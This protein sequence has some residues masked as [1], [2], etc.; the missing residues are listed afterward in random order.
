[1]PPITPQQIKAAFGFSKL[2]FARECGEAF[3]HDRFRTALESFHYLAERTGIGTLTAPPGCGKSVLLGTFLEGLSKTA[4]YPVYLAHTTCGTIDL[5]R[6]ILHGFGVEPAYRKAD[7]YRQLQERLLSLSRDKRIRPLIAIDEAQRLS[8]CFLE[9]IR[10]FTNFDC[11]RSEEVVLILA[12]HPQLTSNL[13]LAINEPL[14]QRIIVRATLGPF[15]RDEMVAYVHFRLKTVGRSAPIFTE[16][17]LEA[18]YKASRGI[19]RIIDHLAER[20]LIEALR[21]KQ[22]E[23]NSQLVT[24]L[25]IEAEF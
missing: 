1:M 23:I 3:D 21:Q 19:P 15:S 6:Q 14:A 22:K 18:L 9:E 25:M 24:S 16:C 12:G 8:R 10:L 7:L 13:R 17:G 20:S 2:P 5:Y 4:Y 11:D